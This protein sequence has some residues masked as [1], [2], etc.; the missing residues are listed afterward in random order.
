MTLFKSA[1][2]SLCVLRLSAIGDVC[3][4]I[5]VVQ[6]IQQQWPETQIT[7]VTGKIEAQLLKSISG[8]EVIVFD[9]SRGWKAY[10]HLWKQLKGQRFDALLH[11]QYA[12]RASVATLGIKARYKLGFDN[13]RSQ[14]FQTFFTNVK[15]PSPDSMHVLD[16]LRAFASELGVQNTSPVWNLQYLKSD[17]DWANNYLQAKK[18]NLVIVP[19]ASKDYKNWTVSGYAK[20]VEHAYR[21][22]WNILLAGSPAKNEV[23]LAE[24]LEDALSIPVTNLVGKSSLLQLLALLD[25]TDLV[26]APDTGPTHMANAMNTPVIGLYAHHNPE[27]TGPYQ[28]REY[29]VSVYAEAIQKETNCSL[30]ELSWRSRV[31]D[32]DAMQQIA[33]DDVIA[34]FD[35]ITQDF[36]LTNV[37]N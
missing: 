27:R 17:L 18:R 2:K 7:W 36:N 30:D 15:V 10:T 16:G 9:K 5:A 19:A 28:F 26:I 29:V 34:M 11:M 4:T 6:S 22:G 1:P 32:K 23:E 31:K 12:I 35:K 14:D 3:N 37:K 13:V 33:A 20:V 21:N 25:K 8:I 24:R